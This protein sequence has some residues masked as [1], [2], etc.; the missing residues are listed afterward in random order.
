[1]SI[2]TYLGAAPKAE[3]HLHLEGSIRPATVLELA[4]RND[5]ALPYDSVEGL[6][7]WF[8]CRDFVHLMEVYRTIC[9]CLRTSGDFE[10]SAFEL[11]A[12]L[13]RQNC[14][15]AEVGFT[16]AIH[17]RRAVAPVTWLDG[18]SRA[19]ER[20][21]DTLGVE[22]AWIFDIARGMRGGAD[23]TMRWAEYTV[24]V[25]IEAMPSGVV[26]LGLGGPEAGFPPEPF[27]P[28]FVRAR[29]AGL[30][31][32]PHAGE[33]AGPES[34]RGALNAL[35]AERLAHGVRA[36]EDPRLVEE[37]ARRRI[38]L[39]LCPTS[40]VCLGVYPR[41][42]DHPLGHLH[43]HDVAITVNS[44][45]PALFNT[46]LDDEVATL[47]DPFG[48]DVAAIDEILLNGL[49]H[50]FLPESRKREMEGAYRAEMRRLKGVHLA[51]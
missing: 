45:D 18:L 7:E 2:Q 4:R 26:A 37:L 31:S 41:L 23:E 20:A 33:L 15:Y 9:L 43:A 28:L 48:L 14:R 21:R 27:A 24:G 49:R 50:S 1:V 11:A 6:T 51:E 39:D 29:A 46:T 3:L 38:A 30:R 47:A 8:V 5:V 35:G 32:F 44:D 19:R 25:A 16:P 36:V 42:A 22:I 34:I 13:A 40:N 12:E 17:A 10:L